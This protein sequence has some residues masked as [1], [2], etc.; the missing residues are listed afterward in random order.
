MCFHAPDPVADLSARHGAERV[1]AVAGQ[2]EA[3]MA[4][5]DLEERAEFL[6]ELDGEISG[7]DRLVRAGY[8]L[9]DLITFY[10]LA[11]GK[12]QAWQLPNGTKAPRAAICHWP[13]CKK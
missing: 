6:A 5:L 3:E 9:L 7:V 13:G 1:I 10:T 8:R 4:G 12:L 11:N 2:W